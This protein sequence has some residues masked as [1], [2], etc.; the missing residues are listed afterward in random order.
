[1]IPMKNSVSSLNVL[2][3]WEAKVICTKSVFIANEKCESLVINSS[4]SHI[5]YCILLP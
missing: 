2:S 5:K 3:K 1:M 4:T